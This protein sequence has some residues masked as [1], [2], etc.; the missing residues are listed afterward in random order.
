[1]FNFSANLT[2]LFTE[3]EFENRFEA[4]SQAGFKFVEMTFPYQWPAQT[5][6]DLLN[7]NGLQ[8]VLFNMPPGNLAAGDL[9][10]ASNPD[11]IDEFRQGVDLASE[12][13]KI[14][15]V[16]R[17]NCLAGKRIEGI[18][19]A[20]Q[21]RVLKE[22]LGYAAGRLA[23]ENRVLLVEPL[24][25]VDFPGFFVSHSDVVVRL[26]EEIKAPNFKLQY[27]LYHM[28]KMEGNLIATIRRHFQHIGHIQVGDNPDRMPPGTGEI[29][30][31]NVVRE[32]GRLDYKG[33]I[34]LEYKAVPDTASA[35]QWL[36]QAD[37]LP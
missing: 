8:Q 24:N 9:G 21:W 19:E 4:A 29:N 11:R 20:D 25:N 30:V 6:K 5:I 2:F 32:L 16:P 1:M 23:E 36:Q 3:L 34:G 27:D 31:P 7:K 15:D 10:L 17:I 22:N 18:P 35:L 28:Q 26:I 14:L 13:A 37:L 33:F 12:Y